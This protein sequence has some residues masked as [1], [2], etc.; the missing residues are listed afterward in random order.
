M[1]QNQSLKAMRWALSQSLRG[2]RNENK[3]RDSANLLVI[4]DRLSPD[5]G[6]FGS[7]ERTPMIQSGS[8]TF[9]NTIFMPLDYNE[10]WNISVMDVF[11]NGEHFAFTGGRFV[12]YDIQPNPYNANQ[13]RVWDLTN[14]I[15]TC[16]PKVEK[17][18]WNSACSRTDSDG[19]VSAPVPCPIFFTSVP[20]NSGKY[21][22]E[23]AKCDES[24]ISF[25]QRYDLNLNF[26]Y[27][28]DP[29]GDVQESMLWQWQ[30]I[31][32]LVGN[33]HIN[34]DDGV[35]V[36]YDI[37]YDRKEEVIYR[38]NTPPG[39][40]EPPIN[41]TRVA[42]R[43][44]V[45]DAQKGDIDLSIDDTDKIGGGAQKCDGDTVVYPPQ[46]MN[47][48]LQ[49]DVSIYTITKEG[50][51]LQVRQG[52]AFNPENGNFVRN[53]TKKDQVDVISR[54]FQLSNDTGRF[55]GP[56]GRYDTIGNV[57]FNRGGLFNP[58][59]VCVNSKTGEGNCF[60]NTTVSQTCFDKGT[61]M[62]F[63]R[64]RIEEKRGRKWVTQ[65]E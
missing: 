50:T 60:M 18:N 9:S 1:D 36:S 20:I 63:I 49:K 28:D 54:M 53:I 7:L 16:F 65:L 52:K 25:E 46:P 35:Y 34:T 41:D 30:G 40:N 57:P 2:V 5:P 33:I 61:K 45:L 21:C 10:D 44:T 3:S 12:T 42:Q 43:I 32:G 37:D 17:G 55:C 29:Q 58:V 8:G 64:S 24:A 22:K 11:V 31:E 13:I 6:K 19:N 48:G 47:V 27:D 51:Y 4:E 15:Q 62:I 39:P 14:H 56:G 59:E 38:I 26:H 23:R